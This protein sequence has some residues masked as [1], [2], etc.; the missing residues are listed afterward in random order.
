MARRHFLHRKKDPALK[1]QVA[2]KPTVAK[3]LEL[4]RDRV[5]DRFA[6]MSMAGLRIT[7]QYAAPW[8]TPRAVLEKLSATR[9]ADVCIPATEE[10]LRVMPR[11][12]EPEAGPQ[13]VLDKPHLRPP[14]QPP[15][16]IRSGEAIPPAAAPSGGADL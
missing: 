10:R 7:R 1:R 8:L 9:R 11:H 13:L 3:L 2:G 16:R 5:I 15:P 14:S 4:V 12:V 6:H